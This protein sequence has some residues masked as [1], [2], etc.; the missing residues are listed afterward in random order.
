MHIGPPC[1]AL[2]AA[3]CLQWCDDSRATG[4]GQERGLQRAT[5]AGRIKE[6]LV[7]QQGIGVTL[8]HQGGTLSSVRGALAILKISVGALRTRSH[9][10]CRF[11]Y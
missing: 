8:P 10:H 4:L 9:L 6:H 2:P 11:E 3:D 5:Q 1:S 7:K